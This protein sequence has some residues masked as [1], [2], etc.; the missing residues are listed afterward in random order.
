MFTGNKLRTDPEGG[1]QKIRTPTNEKSQVDIGFLVRIPSV[2]YVD[3]Y[4][5]TLSGPPPDGIFWN[6]A[7]YYC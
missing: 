4:K 7:L 2:K 6:R 3:G 5:N 1:G